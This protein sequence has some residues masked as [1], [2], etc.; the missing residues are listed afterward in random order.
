MVAIATLVFGVP[1]RGSVPTLVAGAAI[2]VLATTG[3]GLLMSTFTRTQVAALF[4]TAILTAVPTVQFSGL[5]QPVSSLQG[6]AQVIGTLFPATYFMKISV[7]TFTKAL[8]FVDLL[9]Q[10]AALALFFPIL[11]VA[12][13]LLLRGQDR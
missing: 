12:A 8:G 2:Y 7:G 13:V 4:G 10:F 5:L 11:L 6:G 1:V 9:P 3:I